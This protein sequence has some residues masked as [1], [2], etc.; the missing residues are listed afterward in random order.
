MDM[1]LA[2]VITHVMDIL[3]R[4]II[5]VT[6][7]QHVPVTTHVMC[8]RHAHATIHAMVTRHA[9]ATI[10]AINKDHVKLIHPV[11]AT[12]LATGIRHAPVI[13]HAMGIR[14]RVIIPAMVIQRVHATIPVMEDILPAHVIIP[15]MDT[16]HVQHATM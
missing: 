15:V 10:H 12:T 7:I 2:R 3:A 1:Y 13:I 4:V 8:T 14:A 11:D 9:H 5:R 16:S 6:V